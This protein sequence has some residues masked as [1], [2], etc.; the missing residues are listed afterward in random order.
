MPKHSAQV[1]VYPAPAEMPEIWAGL[2]QV[3]S[4]NRQGTREGKTINTTT[5]YITS[6]MSRGY[7]LASAIRGHRQIENNLHWVKDVILKEDKCGIRQ[8]QRA[9]T[10][11]VFR[12]MSF[13]LLIMNKFRSIT[14]G[15]QAL[16]GNV[17]HLWQMITS[18]AE[19]IGA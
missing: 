8:P 17:E 11:G 6:E 16:A 4:V 1:K 2:K 7:A 5:Y 3:I 14:A 10:L 15:I 19:K 18:P 12:D 9:A 13:N